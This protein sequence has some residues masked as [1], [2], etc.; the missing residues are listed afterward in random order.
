MENGRDELTRKARLWTAVAGLA[1]V[2]ITG[3]WIASGGAV[4]TAAKQRDTVEEG[5]ELV[6]TIR[7]ARC[8]H[9]V[10][11]RVTADR[12]YVG[13]TLKQMQ[14]AFGDWDITSYAPKQVEMSRSMPLFCPDHLVVM[15]DGMGTLGVYFN[16]YGDGYALKN[17][18]DIPLSDLP[19]TVRETVHLGLGFSSTQEIE[20]WLETFES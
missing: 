4:S 11:R 5:C 10:T 1:L 2:I 15:P 19:E 9:T 3:I 6:Q 20:N 18:L 14:E 12:E 8:G 16:E 7:Y 13:C 17:E